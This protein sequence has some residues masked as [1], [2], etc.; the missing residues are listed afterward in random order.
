MIK[1][2]REAAGLKQ[3]ELGVR[4]GYGEDLVS[5]V[6]RGRRV[7]KPEFL[8]NTDA[9][10]GANGKI[11]AMKKDVAEARYPKKVRNLVKLEEHIVELGAYGN[12]NLHGLLQTEDYARALFAM[13]RPAYSEDEIDRQVTARMARKKIFDRQPAPTLIFVQEEVTLRRP[14]GGRTVFRRQLEHLLEVGRLRHVELQVM[15]TGCEEHAGM[16]GG[17]RV[18][19]M[20]NGATV[21][22]LETQLSHRLIWDPKELQLITMRYG[23]L[24]AQALTP[25]ESLQFIEKILGET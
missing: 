22:F 1:V 6:E 16:G 11:S 7:P 4:I 5:S 14:L 3:S 10:L 18:L 24:R 9:V 17:L 19:K 15:P 25:R 8:D 12:H 13:R 23:M 20:D 2:W 21:G